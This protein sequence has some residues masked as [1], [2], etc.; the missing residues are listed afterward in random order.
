[1]SSKQAFEKYRKVKEVIKS[2]KNEDQLRVGVK[3]YNLLDRKY[4][5]VIPPQYME[6]LK[7]IVGLMRMKCGIEKEPIDEERTRS[8]VG[9]TFRELANDSGVDTLKNTVWSESN[10]D[11]LKE[12]NIGSQIEGNHCE[13]EVAKE[14]ATTNVKGISDYYSNPDYAILA[15]EN[16]SGDIKKTIR[17]SKEEMDNLHNDGEVPVDGV[18]L[19]YKPDLTEDLEMEDIPDSLSRQLNKTPRKRFNKEEI[20]SKIQKLKDVEYERR[21]KEKQD[22]DEFWERL[23]GEEIEEATG[24][25]SSGQYTGELFSGGEDDIIRKKFYDIPVTGN[26]LVGDKQ[27]GLPISKVFSYGGK[28]NES[29]ILEEDDLE[30]AMSYNDAVGAYDTP[31]FAPS[32]FMGTAGKKGKAPV[33]KGITHQKLAY[34]GGDFVKIKKRCSKYP[35]CNQ[36]PEAIKLS[37]TPFT[38]NKIMKKGN[39]KIKK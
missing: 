32:A 36:S 38:E 7:N 18:N 8:K 30:E 37:K 28:Q 14:L 22:D 35:Y 11:I 27:T 25:G 33:N 31:G 21:E 26:G 39:L 29:E 13:P 17:I 2:C 9:D 6:V 15:I 20:H 4:S 5:D 3:L 12:I 34:P 19:M 10:E 16:E 23:D 24:T 1:M